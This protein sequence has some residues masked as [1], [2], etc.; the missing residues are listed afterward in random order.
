MITPLNDRTLSIIAD[1]YAKKLMRSFECPSELEIVQS[2]STMQ[3]NKD[4]SI[5]YVIPKKKFEA[6][7]KKY[8]RW[9]TNAPDS[10][11]DQGE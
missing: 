5:S 1:Y 8:P 2:C 6:L 9:I 7:R 3:Y 11:P 4:L 10:N